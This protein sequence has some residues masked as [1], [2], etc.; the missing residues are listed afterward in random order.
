MAGLRK[1]ALAARRSLTDETRGHASLK[2]CN[3]IIHSHEFMSCNT[4]ACYLPVNDEVDPTAVIERAWRAKKRVFAPVIDRRGNMIFRQLTPDTELE[5]NFFGIWETISG[6]YVSAST[7]DLVIA[8]VVAFD[9]QHNRI[10]MGGG[11][12]DR[13]FSFLQH[14]RNWL[15]PKLVGA[16]FDC[17]KIEK[18][19][20]NPWDIRLY[21]VV[22]ENS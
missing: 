9:N 22:T 18:I 4:I 17:Q 6:P 2:I 15:R 16:A 11:Y 7:I 14:R 13:C 10:G 5:R 12:Y 21:Q 19:L 20:P 8:P 1:S 3:H